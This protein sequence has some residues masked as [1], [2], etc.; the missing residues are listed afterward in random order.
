M[1]SVR[2]AVSGLG[3]RVVVACS[4]ALVVA[5]GAS[6]SRHDAGTDA[7]AQGEAG[8]DGGAGGVAGDGGGTAGSSGGTAGAAAGGAGSDA[9]ASDTSDDTSDAGV[10]D[11]GAGGAAG[12]GEEGIFATINGVHKAFTVDLNASAPG[13]NLY[14]GAR[15]TQT[16]ESIG[17][18]LYSNY[19]FALPS[20]NFFQCSL[21]QAV[22]SYSNGQ[23]DAGSAMYGARSNRGECMV[24]LTKVAQATND[25]YEGFFTAMFA[26]DSGGAIAYTVVDG[27]FRL[28][29]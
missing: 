9:A 11:D 5:C 7:S 26:P 8:S 29:R 3:G 24:T 13:M 15:I 1:R 10:G 16:T 21:G 20:Q 14:L 2:A 18:T 17:L 27:T 12:A 25:F 19:S 6:S 28:K 4:L 23:G 22:L